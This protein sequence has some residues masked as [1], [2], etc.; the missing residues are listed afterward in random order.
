M[1]KNVSTPS[2]GVD[3]TSQLP[4]QDEVFNTQKQEPPV[5]K[6]TESDKPEDL[7]IPVSQEELFKGKDK[8]EEGKAPDGEKKSPS[9]P[10]PTAS[11]PEGAQK[12][13]DP[14][15]FAKYL[16]E[17]GL[18]DELNEEEFSKIASES[19]DFIEPLKVTIQENF[20][21]RERQHI[22]KL[23]E[24]ARG[25]KEWKEM[26]D[27]G[28]DPQEAFTITYQK[29]KLGAIT[30]DA[31]KENQDLRKEVLYNYY[32]ET[33]EFTD[34]E[35]GDLVEQQV[36]LKKDVDM[37]K[38]ALPKLMGILNEREKQLEQQQLAQKAEQQKQ[39]ESQMSDL[40]TKVLAVDEFLGNKFHSK[41]KDK[42][43]EML[44]KPVVRYENGME[45]NVIWAEYN[46]DPNAFMVK[47]AVLKELGVWDGKIDRVKQVAKNE[48]LEDI[49]KVITGQAERIRLNGGSP[50]TKNEELPAQKDA[51]KRAEEKLD[52]LREERNPLWKF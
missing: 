18:L 5:E 22:E 13:P 12:S 31:L 39:L 1:G 41:T 7:K 52:Q 19:G 6:A 33:T 21:R 2:V 16:K 10:A 50:S 11:A 44:T 14:L 4:S 30:E 17:Q 45:A 8:K 46:K 35:I 32:K 37:S 38:V 48:A 36:Q 47:V 15:V 43:Y 26:L 29:E 27:K 25:Y 49:Q 34:Q 23:N 9:T 42:I 24:E 28:I 20:S 40:K 51:R 3:F